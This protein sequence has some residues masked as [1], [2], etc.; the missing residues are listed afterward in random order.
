MQ[1]NI[2]YFYSFLYYYPLEACIQNVLI[3]N[4]NY[5]STTKNSLLLFNTTLNPFVRVMAKTTRCG[6]SEMLKYKPIIRAK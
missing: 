4:L 3:Q 5:C 1:K 6:L 2:F